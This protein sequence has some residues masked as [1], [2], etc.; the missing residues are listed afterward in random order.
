[1]NNLVK[2]IPLKT[3]NKYLIFNDTKEEF[4]QLVNITD[5]DDEHKSFLEEGDK[6]LDRY[7]NIKPYK[8]NLISIHNGKKYIN[9]SPINIIQ[10]KYF[11]TTQ[12]PKRNTIEDFWTMVEENESNI[13][14]MLCNVIE[15]GK[16]KCAKYWDNKLIKIVSE[17]EKEGYY[18][19]R[20]FKLLNE[21]ENKSRE[22]T[23]L[24]FT[25]WPDHGIPEI[26]NGQVFEIF[27]EMIK[28]IDKKKGDKPAIVHC[29]AGV[30][31]T[32]VFLG[33]Y[34]LYEE[35]MRQISQKNDPIKFCIFNVVRKMKEMRLHM[36][37]NAEQY[38]FLYFFASYLLQKYNF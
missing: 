18:I 23:Q 19:I 22:I 17:E 32:G 15:Q 27:E 10:N 29:S 5:N 2:I 35:I 36:V 31:R 1:M 33:M 20:K 21:S 4:S 37:Q 7:N 26:G 25:A 3:G 38:N 6:K 16:E 34:Y 30:G 12:G 13:I 11:I 28:I 8:Y 14:V 24:H 9:A